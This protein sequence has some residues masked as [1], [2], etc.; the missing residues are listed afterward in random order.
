MRYVVPFFY[1]LL[2]FF[3]D[4]RLLTYTTQPFKNAGADGPKWAA[5]V[6]PIIGGKAGGKPGAHTAIG[7][8]TN[9]DKV[10][11]G[12]AEATKFIES[13]KL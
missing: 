13:L 9:A 4:K 10:D 12:V 11:E 1:S 5:A 7:Q 6:T 8:G 3:L 2:P